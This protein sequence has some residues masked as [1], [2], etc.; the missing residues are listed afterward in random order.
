LERCA[1]YLFDTWDWPQA[2]AESRRALELDPNNAEAHHLYSYVLLVMQRPEEALREQKRSTELDPFARPWALGATYIHLRRFDVALNE[3][4]VFAAAQPNH[5]GVRFALCQ[6]FWFK[7]MW[8]ES[9]QQLEEGLRLTGDKKSAM[10]VHQAFETGGA[11][12]VEQWGVA[13]IERQ[14]IKHHVAPFDI[15]TQYAFL[16]DKEGTLRSLEEAYRERSPWLVFLQNEPEFDF[17]HSDER[18]RA[19]VKKIGLPPAY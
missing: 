9:E 2:E 11:R 1:L 15:A 5:A 8:K 16:G 18:Y 17:L 10:G 13:N 14:A 4:R 19:I 3:L 12:G 7:R 6:A